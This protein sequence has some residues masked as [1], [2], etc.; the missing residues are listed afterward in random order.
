MFSR[1]FRR[2]PDQSRDHGDLAHLLASYFHQD[3]LVVHGSEEGV[4][5]DFVKSEES[6]TVARTITDIEQFVGRHENDLLAA[7]QRWFPYSFIVGED[8]QQAREWFD[9]L[10]SGLR[11]RLVGKVPRH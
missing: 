4:L 2:R 9:W 6:S 7:Y 1:L 10:S 11:R 8:D 5:D 3:Y